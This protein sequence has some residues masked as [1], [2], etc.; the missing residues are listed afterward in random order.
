LDLI[1]DRFDIFGHLFDEFPAR[2]SVED[3]VGNSGGDECVAVVVVVLMENNR[4]DFGVLVD[5][6]DQG[7]NVGELW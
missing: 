4:V 7:L 2:F 5:I 1:G 3:N 6:V